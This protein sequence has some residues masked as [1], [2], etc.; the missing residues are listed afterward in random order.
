MTQQPAGTYSLRRADCSTHLFRMGRPGTS[1]L[2][3]GAHETRPIRPRSPF[4]CDFPFKTK[5]PPIPPISFNIWPW[6]SVPFPLLRL[7]EILIRYQRS[8]HMG[9][10]GQVS[11]PP[12]RSSPGLIFSLQEISS[13]IRLVRVYP[14]MPF[15]CIWSSVCYILFVI[16]LGVASPWGN[17]ARW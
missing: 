2:F 9:F 11:C 14:S 7:P 8:W 16:P 13:F 4:V 1:Y 12:S 3:Q 5:F 6:S 15:V 10:D 17:S